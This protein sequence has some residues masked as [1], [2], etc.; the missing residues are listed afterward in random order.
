MSIDSKQLAQDSIA[1]FNHQASKQYLLDKYTALLTFA[2]QGGMW[3]AS[4]E[5]IAFLKLCNNNVV[6]KDVFDNP[7][8]VHAP[9]LHQEMLAVY[10]KVMSDWHGEYTELNQES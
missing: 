4:P 8:Q 7:V 10:K 9:T 2:S 3:T 1:R 6:I 5:L